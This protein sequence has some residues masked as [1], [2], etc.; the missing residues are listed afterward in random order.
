MSQFERLSPETIEKLKRVSTATAS[1]MLLK[2]G[3]RNT[4]ME[5]V[6]PLCPEEVLVGQAVTLRYLPK[7]ED[8]DEARGSAPRPQ[9]QAIESVEPGDVLV[10]EARGHL[11]CATAGDILVTRVKMRGAAGYVTDGALRDTPYIRTMA[12]PIYVGGANGQPS[13]RDFSDIDFNQPIACGGVAVL[14]G[15]VILGDGEGVVVIPRKY[16][17]EIAEEGSERERLEIF[18][19]EQ[20]EQGAST[21]DVYPPTPEYLERYEE[22]AKTHP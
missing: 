17:Q 1:G 14:P 11:G 20:V 5:G 12:Y 6:Y 19:R 13:P 4:F 21:F 9:R 22:W 10:V 8:I 2:L 7:R 15:D 18:I 3:I 16:V